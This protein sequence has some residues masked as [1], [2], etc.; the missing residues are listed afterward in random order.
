MEVT[1]SSTQPSDYLN[2]PLVFQELSCGSKK[3]FV[4]RDDFLPAG[5]KGRAMVDYMRNSSATDFI[6]AGPVTGYA[7]VVLAYAASL[8][9]K[10]AHI[11][12]EKFEPR[13]SLTQRAM[14]AIL[15][16]IS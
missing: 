7:Q 16:R 15:L 13:S 14:Y 8:C 5:T 6:Y 1:R 11:F 10:R 2:P 9:S 12:V 4:I 3:F